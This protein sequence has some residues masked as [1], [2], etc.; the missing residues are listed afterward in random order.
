MRTDFD[1]QWEQLAE[2]VMSGMKEWRLQHPEASLR[3]IENALDERL[4]RMRARMLQDAA[5]ASSV[6]DIKGALEAERPVCV[7]CGGKLVE[8]TRAVRRL[9]TQHNQTLELE[10]SYGVCSQCGAGVFPPRQA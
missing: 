8:R 4:G 3:E 1:A 9:V 10:R 2:E 7:E 6:A 5:L